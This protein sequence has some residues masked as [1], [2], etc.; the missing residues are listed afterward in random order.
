MAGAA[1]GAGSLLSGV[2]QIIP[3]VFGSGTEEEGSSVTKGISTTKQKTEIDQAGIDKIIQD[4]LGG[5]GGLAEIFA[6]EQSSG[7]FNSTVAAQAAGDLASKLTGEIAKL[8]AET[9]STT[10]HD[11]STD[12]EA[13]SDQDDLFQSIFGDLGGGVGGVG[14]Q[15]KSVAVGGVAGGAAAGFRKLKSLF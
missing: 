14:D 3:A 4:V 12:S 13:E 1:A 5:A 2:A 15:L 8:Q 10:V 6:G 7:I 11:E 9:S